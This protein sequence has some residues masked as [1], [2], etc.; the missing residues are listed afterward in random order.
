MSYF[1]GGGGGGGGGG[2]TTSYSVTLTGL[3]TGVHPGGDGT[4]TIDGKTWYAQNVANSDEMRTVSGEGLVIDCNANATD[5]YGSTRTGP[6]WSIKTGALG[7]PVNTEFRIWTIAAHNIDQNY[8][9]LDIGVEQFQSTSY[10][11]VLARIFNA[12]GKW[13]ARRTVGGVSSGNLKPNFLSDDAYLVHCT[14]VGSIDIYTGASSGGNFPAF[15]SMR[16]QQHAEI[17]FSGGSPD[18]LS[19]VDLAF[20]FAMCPGPTNTS[21]TLRGSLKKLLVEYKT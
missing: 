3:A 11:I 16:L 21:N 6:N 9:T 20:V 10:R 7:I 13:A 19:E 5:L 12:S 2:W 1:P 17:D 18:I 14:N 8:E 4:V 15:A